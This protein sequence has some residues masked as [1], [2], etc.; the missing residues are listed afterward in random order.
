M[1]DIVNKWA[2]VKSYS[3]GEESGVND[4]WERVWLQKGNRRGHCGEEAV[5]ILAVVVHILH[6]YM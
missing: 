4:G 5:L 6:I 1:V 3:W 2:A